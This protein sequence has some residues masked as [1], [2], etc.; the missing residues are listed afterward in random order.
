MEPRLAMSGSGSEATDFLDTDDGAG[1]VRRQD[2]GPRATQLVDLSHDPTG[3]PAVSVVIPA[4]NEADNIG[5][6]LDR[7]PKWVDEVL[8]VDGASTDGTVAVARRHRADVRVVVQ[9]GTGKGD[10]LRCGFAAAT[11]DV[12]VMLDADGSTDPAEIPRFVAALRTGADFAKGSRF[13]T[14]GGSVDISPHRQLGNRLLI[15]LVNLL[16]GVSFTDLCYGYNAFWRR[17][18]PQLQIESSGFEVETMLNIK[19]IKA[20]L[21]VVEVA[22][23]E[24][25]R[26]NGASNLIA[27][28]DGL[29]VL[30]TILAEWIRPR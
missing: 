1:E 28:R 26:R 29:R 5:F 16:W 18:L 6:V 21:T 11:G 2:G 17:H 10:A 12:I 22:S 27:R 9:S 3:L 8:I 20:D 7:V 13:I 25:G 30:R 4:L 19:A 14:G 15:A 24:S 23:F